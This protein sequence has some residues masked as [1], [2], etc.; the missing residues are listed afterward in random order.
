MKLQWH[1]IRARAAR[2]SEDW[3]DAHYEK[4]E[5][6]SF[7][8]AF[9]RCFG[10]DRRQVGVYE[11]RV[12]TL[13]KDRQGFID[14]FMPGTLIVEQKSAGLDLRKADKQAYDYFDWLPEVERPRYILTCDFQRWHLT[15][16]ETGRE[17]RFHLSE[18]KKH[19]EAFAFI[20]GTPRR[21]FRNQKPANPKA[22]KLLSDLH[23][24]LEEQGYEGHKLQLLLVRLL[25]ILFADDT[26]IWPKDQFLVFLEQRTSADGRDLGRWLSELFEV[27]DTPVEKRQSG[28]DG[29][30]AQ[31]PH[32]NGKL[33]EERIG[34]AVFDNVTR[35]IL[36]DAS[37]FN[38]GEV[39]PAIFGSLFEGVIDKVT[40]RK[41][42]AHYTP[43]EAIL[44]VIGPLF[45]DELWEE[46]EAL[47]ARKDGGR[48]R[49]LIAFHEKLAGLTFFD[50]ACGA[51]NFLVVAY[52]ELRDLE[53]E[54][55]KEIHPPGTRLAFGVEEI[56]KLDVDNFYGIE[57]DEFPSQIAQVAL[58]MTDH[59]ANTNLGD[60]YGE[61]FA[62]I[63]LVTAPNIRQADALEIDWN[64]V[65]PAAECSY[66]FGNPPFVGQSYQSTEQRQ[67]M[68]RI[69]SLGGSGGTLDYV[70]AWFL[71]A[72]DYANGN[73]PH[74]LR[75]EGDHAQHGGGVSR[76]GHTPPP[77]FGR[78]PSPGKPG[79]DMAAPRIA[80]V[81]TN[82]ICQGEQVAQLWP[83][84]FGKHKL[85]IDFAHRTFSWP[86][87]AAVHC[88]VVGLALGGAERTQKRLFS[89]PD[90]K[91]E[92][93]ET[94]HE[95]L[96]AY[97]FAAHTSD[98]QA[99]VVDRRE[100]ISASK[101]MRMGSKIV[102]GGHYIFTATQRAKFLLEQPDAEKWLV[103]LIG[104]KEFIQGGRRWILDLQDAPPDALRNL[105]AV[106]ERIRRVRKF[107][108][109]SKKVATNRLAYTPLMFEVNT[110]PS[111]KFLV[112]PEVSSERRAYIPMGWIEPPAIPTNLVQTLEN[113]TLYDF[114]ILTSAMHMAWLRHIGGRLKSDY[115]YSIGLVY[116]T[117]P[118]PEAS[119]AQR[120]KVEALAQAVLDA[121]AL[122]KNATSTL[123]D[124][125]DP[126][127]M[128]PELHKAHK[129]LDAAVD[130][131]YNPRGF[132]DDRSRV[133]HLFR[134]YEELVMPT[135]AAPRANRR[136]KR[137][138]TRQARNA[139]EAR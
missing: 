93:V 27:L 71:K 115:R 125:Y 66:V 73:P 74:A 26:G 112:V 69:A 24:A 106:R 53:A 16:L 52:R 23:K 120:A 62:R 34:T 83:L 128:P 55:L 13:E 85:E 78:S 131:L 4:G 79:E 138:V 12:Q 87:R 58:W 48:E 116:N 25:F 59:I 22:T 43:E 118:W 107:R 108:E 17:W 65:L 81:A 30:L 133:E 88:V 109:E 70:A 123:A 122:P 132:A 77:S 39:S 137:R 90:I 129:A 80:F 89:Y 57:I 60:I 103:P 127:R 100:P 35:D 92:P 32:I 10:V 54:L 72:G 46:F 1:E 56:S 38:W 20:V 124:L 47:K 51:G 113:A 82:S 42:G 121:R 126:D 50:P 28:L 14:L 8:N 111:E 94:T 105:P 76:R 49:A 135:A 67:Q 36:L 101:P 41:Q 102:D 119:D 44:K 114:A 11:K 40:R 104:S 63:P 84:L 21:Q 95:A 98:R 33:F 19:V 64:E 96:T 31:F 61:P 136:T 68:R 9:F 45:L 5:T 7:Y 15:D 91:G 86:G 6:H 3:K 2:F 29:D 110:R 97:L 130:K 37:A 117:F 18:L 139:G 75:G 134:R 99:V